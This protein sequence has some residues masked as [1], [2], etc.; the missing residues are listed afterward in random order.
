MTTSK[1]RKERWKT[2]GLGERFSRT[3]SEF[4]DHTYG[5]YKVS[6]RRQALLDSLQPKA[7]ATAKGQAGKPIALVSLNR[8]ADNHPSSTHRRF[9]AFFAAAKRCLTKDQCERLELQS[10]FDELCGKVDAD[11]RAQGYCLLTCSLAD[12]LKSQEK[13]ILKARTLSIVAL[14]GD[15]FRDIRI[16]LQGRTE[17]VPSPSKIRHNEG[18]KAFRKRILMEIEGDEP[19]KH[20]SQIHV[21]L[22]PRSQYD[23]WLKLTGR[24]GEYESWNASREYWI[25]YLKKMKRLIPKNDKY[26]VSVALFE[27]PILTDVTYFIDHGPNAGIILGNHLLFGLVPSDRP[28]YEVQYSDDENS[29]YRQMRDAL[30]RLQNIAKSPHKSL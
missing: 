12:A 16:S 15:Y 14:N 13:R 9:L 26:P 21:Y 20:L 1:A 3:L 17:E 22:P 7:S 11:Q 27:C 29:Q 5:D 30:T 8:L 6:L 4:I 24:W 2:G 25:A 10:T 23:A 19:F 18:P 28:T